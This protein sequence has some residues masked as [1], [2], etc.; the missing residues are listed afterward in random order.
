MLGWSKLSRYGKCRFEIEKLVY[1]FK[2]KTG[3]LRI[4]ISKI[5]EVLAFITLTSKC[6]SYKNITLFWI[7]VTFKI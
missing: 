1:G 4:Y 5:T 3:F 2:R 6:Y 7:Y